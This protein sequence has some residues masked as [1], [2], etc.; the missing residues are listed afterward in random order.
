M[1]VRGVQ[2][3]EC[4]GKQNP[5]RVDVSMRAFFHFGFR[6][7]PLS[8]IHSITLSIS[9]LFF[10]YSQSFNLTNLTLISLRIL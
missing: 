1:R 10:V 4:S 2:D 3:E 5:N 6:Y 7:N 8:F 9:I